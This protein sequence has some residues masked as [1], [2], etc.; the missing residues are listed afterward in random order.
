MDFLSP[1]FQKTTGKMIALRRPLAKPPN[2]PRKPPNGPRL[3]LLKLLYLMAQTMRLQLRY[4]THFTFTHF[5]R[6]GKNMA[7]NTFSIAA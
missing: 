5:S 4:V 6:M 3:S 7:L 1:R 2:L